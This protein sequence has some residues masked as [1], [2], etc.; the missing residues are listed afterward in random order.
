MA[1][2][3]IDGEIGWDVTSDMIREQLVDLD[4]DLELEIS[5]PGGSVYQGFSIFSMLKDYKKKTNSKIT[6]RILGLAASIASYIAMIGDSIQVSDNSVFMIHNAWSYSMGD[7]N[8]FRK[9]ADLLERLSDISAKQYMKKSGK[10]EEDIKSLMNEDSYFFGQG[11]VDEGFADNLVDSEDEETEANQLIMARMRIE[12]CNKHLNDE[13]MKDDISKAV[14]LIGKPKQHKTEKSTVVENIEEG[15]N[16]M[17]LHE[18]LAKNPEAKAEYDTLIKSAKAEGITETKVLNKD[19]LEILQFSGLEVPD[20]ARKAIEE[21]MSAK[22]FTYAQAKARKI[23]VQEKAKNPP[24]LKP[25]NNLPDEKKEPVG[26]SAIDAA[27]ER[28]HPKKKEA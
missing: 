19:A 14:A 10:S 23:D 5:S 26:A 17:K 20:A 11:I 9:V 28:L 27:H 12:E 15:G 21:G 7:Y 4:E 22:D 6:V 3:A 18:F 13:K 16:S 2:I 24:A 8:E 1:R 25:D